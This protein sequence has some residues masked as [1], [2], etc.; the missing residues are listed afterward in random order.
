MISA[1]NS[2]L[3]MGNEITALSQLTQ[4]RHDHLSQRLGLLERKA[5]TGVLDLF[6]SQA[7]G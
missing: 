2:N 7:W 6:D 3:Y 5:V 4:E 1:R